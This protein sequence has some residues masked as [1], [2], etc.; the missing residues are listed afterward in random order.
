MSTRRE[1]PTH[2]TGVHR[3][4][5]GTHRAAVRPPAPVDPYRDH[6]DG[7]FTYCLSVMCEHEAAISVLGEAL[8][9]AERQRRRGRTPADTALHRP[10]LYALARWSCLRLLA[11][12]QGVRPEPPELP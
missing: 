5:R 2:T 8:A 1:H 10:W 6:L 9:V 3:A 4:H 7:L 12:R 11:E